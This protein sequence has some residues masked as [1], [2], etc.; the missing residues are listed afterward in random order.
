MLVLALPAY[1]QTPDGLTPAD[2]NV[3][4]PLRSA[5][6]G[7]YGLCFAYCEAH[8]AEL[9]S[10]QGDPDELNTPNQ[11]ILANYNRKKKELDP[12]M[13]CVVEETEAC[14]CWTSA[15]LKEMEPPSGNYDFNFPHAC[16]NTRSV[17]TLE[18]YEFGTEGPG[19]QLSV[20]SRE[21]CHV[22]KD[23]FYPGGPAPGTSSASIEEEESC[24]TLLI[25]HARA[26]KVDGVFWDC[27]DQ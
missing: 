2:E 5:T 22:R 27:F 6:P 21:G 11:K 1:S 8:D 10:P 7:L 18:N 16:R 4:D 13:P 9:I 12:P 25:N 19:Y 15:E 24:R 23:R 14:P 3:C 26:H 17:I 20:F